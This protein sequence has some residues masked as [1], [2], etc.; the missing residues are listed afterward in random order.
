VD[1]EYRSALKRENMTSIKDTLVALTSGIRFLSKHII[2]KARCKTCLEYKMLGFSKSGQYLIYPDDNSVGISVYCDMET[3][4]GG[5]TL[6]WSNRYQHEFSKVTNMPWSEVSSDKVFASG[7]ITDNL[8][9]FSVF[10]GMERYAT[11]V[12]DNPEMRYSWKHYSN[13]S[14]RD[15]KFTLVPPKASDNYALRLSNPVMLEGSNLPGLYTYHNN[16]RMSS[17]DSGSWCASHYG[18]QPF[19]YRS[20]WSGSI[21]GYNTSDGAY[22]DGSSSNYR[23]NGWLW[24]R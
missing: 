5:W 22:W 4:G 18:R 12:G 13:G 10:T 17:A 3:D 1:R 16:Q 15:A 9:D 14:R 19:W 2:L 7:E 11:I 24:I 6:V 21:M 23:G 20:C 8:D